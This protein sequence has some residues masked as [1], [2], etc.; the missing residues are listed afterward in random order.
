M[1]WQIEKYKVNG[2]VI[3]DDLF[4]TRESR[5]HEFCNK[6]FERNISIKFFCH[7]R[8]DRVKK[9]TIE[10]MKK[11]GLLL[12]A[13]G[14][15]SGSQKLLGIM[16]KGTTLEQI[17]SAFKIY[18]EAGI[19]TFGHIILGHPD[20][21]TKDRDLTRELLKRIKPTYDFEI[22]RAK[23]LLGGDNFKEFTYTIDNPEFST[24]IP[25]EELKKIGDE[26]EGMGAVNRNKN[27]FI[28]PSF[29]IFI[30]K[31]LFFH[32]LVILEALYLRYIIHKT[33]QMSILA[34][35]KDAIQF[36]KQKF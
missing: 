5:M 10:L 1:E 26:F 17:E 30:I 22:K 7:A 28:Y 14:V 18:N 8:I 3:L 23:Y 16:N 2:F 35:F 25:L 33:N 6:L 15:E 20:E 24:T 12:L 9:E 4:Y 34:V 11:A 32:P 21:T 13:V 29:I 31:F 36:Y 19:N 27:L